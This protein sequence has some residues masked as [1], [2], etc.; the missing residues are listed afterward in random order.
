MRTPLLSRT[1]IAGFPINLCLLRNRSM[2]STHK[3]ITNKKQP[4]VALLRVYT[5]SLSCTGL[6]FFFFFPQPSV[7]LIAQPR[8]AG[9]RHKM[10]EQDTARLRDLR[11]YR[12]EGR[13]NWGI[14]ERNGYAHAVG[15]VLQ[16][17][18]KT[19][20]HSE[21]ASVHTQQL[22]GHW[23]TRGEDIFNTV[24]GAWGKRG[25]TRLGSALLATGS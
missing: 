1:K 13:E 3:K 5:D 20:S 7:L 9:T 25:A 24:R 14:V 11:T 8:Q 6:T 19:R 16:Q 12:G 21:T 2:K 18:H 15:I 4:T 10:G 22:N 17:R 23:L